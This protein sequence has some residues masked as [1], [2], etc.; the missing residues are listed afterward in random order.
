MEHQ[1]NVAGVLFSPEGQ[2][3][4]TSSLD[5]AARFWHTA[6]CKPIGPVLRHGAQALGLAW[7]PTENLV[8]TASDD[9]ALRLWAVPAPARADL[10]RLIRWTEVLTGMELDAQGTIHVLD[11]KTWQ[12]WADH[13]L[14]DAGSPNATTVQAWDRTSAVESLARGYLA[15]GEVERALPLLEQ[16]VALQT[17]KLG[18]DDPGLIPNLV[19]L[20][21]A[22]EKF[23]RP[24]N[25]VPVAERMLSLAEQEY[26]PV[27]ETTLLCLDHLAHANWQLKRLD[28]SIPLL[29]EEMRRRWLQGGP[30]DPQMLRTTVALAINLRDAGRLAEAI[31]LL[32]QYYRKGRQEALFSVYRLALLEV[33]LKAG[34]NRE[35]TAL[36]PEILADVRKEQPAGSRQL[37]G[38]LVLVA[39][40]LLQAKGFAQAETLLRECLEIRQKQEPDAWTTFN[41]MSMLGEALGGLKKFGEAEP[42]LVTGYEGMKQRAAALPRQGPNRLHEAGTRLVQF[43]EAWSKKDQAEAWRKK[44]AERTAVV[45]GAAK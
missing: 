27:H 20:T 5:G 42:L 40:V 33:Y 24:A 9:A 12:D 17:A 6:S 10:A 14:A 23:G 22:Y 1:G 36:L 37:A 16:A 8:A 32:E 4:F 44:L 7:S 3:L 41:T 39:N 43:Y 19:A 30:Q 34:K 18:Q 35:A 38:E 15:A 28:R 13:Y 31:P 26:G 21:E 25:A 45:P 29:E 11:P 2:I